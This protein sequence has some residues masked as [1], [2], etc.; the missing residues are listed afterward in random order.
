MGSGDE[1]ESGTG[2][3]RGKGSDSA[4]DM[5]ESSGSTENLTGSLESKGCCDRTQC[6]Q[7]RRRSNEDG[8]ADHAVVVGWTDCRWSNRGTQ[9]G[10]GGALSA[11]LLDVS[12]R[13]EAKRRS[14][15]CALRDRMAVFVEKRNRLPAET[16]TRRSRDDGLLSQRDGSHQ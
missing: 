13:C 7:P 9:L 3:C 6:L 10:N 4:P 16:P 1:D 15:C 8:L 14:A 12:L 2:Q 5:A 11:Q